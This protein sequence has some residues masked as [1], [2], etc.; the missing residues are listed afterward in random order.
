MRAEHKAARSPCGGGG[1]AFRIHEFFSEQPE[2]TQ[3]QHIEVAHDGIH[4][5]EGQV[6]LA[7]LNVPKIKF[8][9]THTGRYSSLRLALFHSQ[10]RYR[11]AKYFSWRI[12]FPRNIRSNRL[13]HTVIVADRSLLI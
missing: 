13:G 3:R 7:L 2:S 8:L 1:R 9:A 12:G 5:V 4:H 11:E 6:L 10:T